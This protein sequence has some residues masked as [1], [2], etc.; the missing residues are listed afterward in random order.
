MFN[1][2][3]ILFAIYFL[4]FVKFMI[5]FFILL[6]LNDR[7]AHLLARMAEFKKQA[8]WLASHCNIDYSQT[9]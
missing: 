4:L 1:C 9:W 2:L 8:G 6:S 3:N 5:F 7:E